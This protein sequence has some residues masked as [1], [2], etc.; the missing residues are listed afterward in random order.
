MAYITHKYDVC[1]KTQK[2]QEHKLCNMC[3]VDC[4]KSSKM[5]NN[6]AYCELCF[7]VHDCVTYYCPCCKQEELLCDGSCK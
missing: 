2:D 3:K 5:C 1:N 7:D 6:H 4:K